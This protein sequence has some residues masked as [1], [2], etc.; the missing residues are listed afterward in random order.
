[1]RDD[2]VRHKSDPV[3]PYLAMLA[4][5]SSIAL[6]GARRAGFLL[7]LVAL[8]YWL[9]IGFRF[10]VGMD[11]NNYIFIYE[12]KK[13]LSLGA[14]IFNREPGYGALIWTAAQLRWGTI[15]LNAAS[16]L[17]FCWG[18]FSVARRCPEPWIAVVVATPLLVVAFAMSGARQ[19]VSCGIVFYL[20]A[21]WEDRQTLGKVG[22]ILLATLFHFS[23]VFVLAFV[24]LGSKAPPVVRFGSAVVAAILVLAIVR[25]A[26]QSMEA[27]SRLYVGAEG[28]LSAPGAIVQ[29]GV[30]A[31]AGAIYL[32]SRRRWAAVMGES[33]LLTN[34][35]WGSLACLPLILISSV[36]A[37]RFALYFWPLGM[38][39]YSGFPGLIPAATGRA[40]YRL[41]VV[42][43]S[44]AMLIGWLLLANNSLPWL[45]YKNWLTQ[46]DTVS[47]IRY[48]PYKRD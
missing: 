29:V 43:C 9:M 39:V 42:I 10:Q 18:F 31:I 34:L 32:L 3:F 7:F 19:S 5:P 16:A 17:I 2:G 26:P 1:M 21:T 23:A 6:T 36:G 37:Y 24:A 11:W 48:A 28:K 25:F 45:P 14:L 44:F 41:A 30:L 13:G 22:L 40:F 20:L 4:A 35:A 8:F 38:Y 15:F 12:Q 47:L 33:A 46:S 27:Y